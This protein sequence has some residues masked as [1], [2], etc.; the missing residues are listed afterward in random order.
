[1]RDGAFSRRELAAVAAVLLLPI[2][3]LVA[4]GLRLPLPAAIERGFASLA[5]AESPDVGTLEA[6]PARQEPERARSS[7][8]RRRGQAPVGSQA[9]SPVAVAPKAAAA[10]ARDVDRPHETAGEAETP[11]PDIDGETPPGAD[12]NGPDGDTGG[13]GDQARAG[14][15]STEPTLVAEPSAA[16]EVDASAALVEV[17]VTDEGVE[18]STGG[19]VGARL[20][21]LTVPL[22][23]LPAP[24]PDPPVPLPPLRLP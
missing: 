17:A 8:S 5:P 19:D 2:P 21:D 22:V 3:L 9:A 7:S 23:D 4:S 24:L 18:V 12:E 6:A 13:A 16:V 14:G 10:P 1:M 15:E 20:P 11:T